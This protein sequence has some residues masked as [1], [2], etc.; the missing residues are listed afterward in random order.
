[1][2]PTTQRALLEFYN[3]DERRWDTLR[4]FVSPDAD[5]SPPLALRHLD[6]FVVSFSRFENVE[7]LVVDGA[8]N[9]R[10]FAVYGEYKAHLKLHSKENFDPFCRGEKIGMRNNTI[11]TAW[12]QMNFFAWAMSP[13]TQVLAYATAPR[14]ATR[15]LQAYRQ[16]TKASSKK[17]KAT[18][19][20]RWREQVV[21]SFP[22]ATLVM[23]SYASRAGEHGVVGGNTDDE[24]QA[25]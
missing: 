8:G 19:G 11:H 24:E 4:R 17:R 10:S 18:L 22:T 3:A 16:H 21:V 12:R 9:T 6:Y 20:T 1:M 15:I 7:Y 23:R 14:N 5:D 25:T 2:D 13:Q